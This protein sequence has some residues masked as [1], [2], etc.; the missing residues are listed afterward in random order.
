MASHCCKSAAGK[1]AASAAAPSACTD[2][3]RVTGEFSLRESTKR[4]GI[5]KKR[6]PTRKSILSHHITCQCHF[7]SGPGPAA[8]AT[9]DGYRQRGP[10]TR[11]V[12][13]NCHKLMCTRSFQ[14]PPA[15][16]TGSASE[17]ASEYQPPRTHELRTINFDG[18]PLYC[19][20]NE[21]I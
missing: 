10:P 2:S 12:K 8:A 13:I 5:K 4:F 16:W 15:T 20:L 3:D 14:T 21:K 11:L 17:R 19:C 18:P 9:A 6:T 7:H 1:A